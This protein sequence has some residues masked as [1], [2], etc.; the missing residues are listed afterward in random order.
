[1]AN[2]DLSVHEL[3]QNVELSEDASGEPVLRHTP[4]GA[5]FRYNEA[6]D[7]WRL[8]GG[9]ELSAETG[10][11]TATGTLTV[12]VPTDA[13]T[14]NEGVNVATELVEP[15]ADT[16]VQVNI[17][18]GHA[19]QEPIVADGGH[20]GHVRI[21]SEDSV[22]P[23]SSGFPSAGITLK[24]FNAVMPI[25]DCV[26]DQEGHGGPGL[27]TRASVGRVAEGAG[28]R[29][30]G[31]EG[32]FISRGSAVNLLKADFSGSSG[33]HEVTTASVAS[34]Q[35]YDGSNSGE[36][37]YVSR[38]A[39]VNAL[40]ADFSGCADRPA[41]VRRSR[42]CLEDADIS[43][44][45]ANNLRVLLGSQVSAQGLK[46]TGMPSR[47]VIRHSSTAMLRNANLAAS[48]QNVVRVDHADVNLDG[49]SVSGSTGRGVDIRDGAS[50][51][52]NG[53]SFS[54]IGGDALGVFRGSLANTHSATVDASAIAT[55]DTNFSS[56]NSVTTDGIVFN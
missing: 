23:T 4:S 27:S 29:N 55:G 30:A 52:L 12:N 8:A 41:F 21:V 42:V 38:N 51:N 49:A 7:A 19:I 32:I 20:Y 15:R 10:R 28:V 24:S 45:S 48:G 25:L 26:I 14:V 18:A 53:T 56:F 13:A 22:V 2:T 33:R 54:S 46:A 47:V 5:T 35:R 3:G 40:G 43:N 36:G 31:A 37:L 39:L 1:M 16:E 11:V 17:E 6:D 9:G 44:A 50:A 34:M